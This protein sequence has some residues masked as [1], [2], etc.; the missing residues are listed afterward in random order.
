[1]VIVNIVTE[2]DCLNTRGT[3]VHHKNKTA[4]TLEFDYLADTML[5]DKSLIGGCIDVLCNKLHLN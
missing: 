3:S 5:L 4:K 2:S 1:M